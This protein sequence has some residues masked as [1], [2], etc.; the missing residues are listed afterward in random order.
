MASIHPTHRLSVLRGG[1]YSL[2]DFG[3]GLCHSAIFGECRTSSI[4]QLSP[5]NLVIRAALH[6]RDS[7]L[8]AGVDWHLDSLSELAIAHVAAELDLGLTDELI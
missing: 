4:A 8:L 2:D 5:R 6:R 7:F 1:I 3:V